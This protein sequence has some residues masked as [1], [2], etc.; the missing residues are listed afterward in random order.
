MKTGIQLATQ[1]RT[2]MI[3]KH[4]RTVERDVEEN[5]N[6]E[7]LDGALAILNGDREQFPPHWN[8]NI[9]DKIMNKKE[10]VDKLAIAAA[11]IMAEID[12]IQNTK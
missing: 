3:E 12:R 4:G 7:L 11:F 2:E 9:C 5:P 6:G 10:W 1:E 8:E